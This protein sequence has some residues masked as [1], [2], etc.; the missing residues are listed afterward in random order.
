MRFPKPLK[1]NNTI[2]FVSPSFNCVEEPYKTGFEEGIKFLND[3]GYKTIL[4]ANAYATGG[5]GIC[6]TP[7]SCAKELMDEYIS[8]ASEALISCGGGEL[9]CE[10]ISNVDFDA[11]KAAEPKWY[12]GYSDNTNFTFLLNTICDVASIYGYCA[13]TFGRKPMHDSLIKS[14]ELLESDNC[15]SVHSYDKYEIES[16]KTPENPCV[17]FNLTEDTHITGYEYTLDGHKEVSSLSMN[18]RLVGG[19][20]DC[21]INLCGTRFDKVSEFNE[22]YK[23]DGIIWFLESCDLNVYDMRRAMWHLKEAGWFKYA[24][25]FIIGRPVHSDEMFGLD[26]K[27][28]YIKTAKELGVPIVFGADIGHV[29]PMMPLISGAY[30]ELAFDNGTLNIKMHRS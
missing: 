8:E 4:G 20:L 23:E 11:I 6:S 18:G 24:K 19:C 3:R 10:T 26:V 7:E 9:M 27:N 14:M 13:S 28:A 25:G 1:E 21:L 17:A 5:I 16:L 15:V 2:G 30:S 22:R 12:M 29:P